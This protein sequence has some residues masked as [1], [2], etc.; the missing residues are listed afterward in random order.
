MSAICDRCNGSIPDGGGYVFYSTAAM[1]FAGM[2]TPQETGNMMLCDDCTGQ[3]I[4]PDGYAS[5]GPDVQEV[6]GADILDNPFG[7]M[8]MMRK[9]NDSAIIKRCRA[10]GLTPEQAR[11]KAREFAVMWWKDSDAAQVASRDFWKSTPAAAGGCVILLCALLPIPAAAAFVLH[12]W[13]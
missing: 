1:G 7:L 13:A 11:E 5:Q 2:G 6:S 8:E 4:T 3:I 10:H 9:A 12:W